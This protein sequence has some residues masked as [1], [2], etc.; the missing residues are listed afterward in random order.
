MPP[1][2]PSPATRLPPGPP[3]PATA[4]KCPPPGR[5]GPPPPLA[6]PPLSPP[7][8]PSQTARTAPAAH[9]RPGLA[10]V[11][12][13]HPPSCA[14]SGSQCTGPPACPAAAQSR[15]SPSDTSTKTSPPSTAPQPLHPPR[16]SRHRVPDSTH[17]THLAFLTHLTSPFSWSHSSPSTQTPSSCCI[18][19][20]KSPATRRS[21]AETCPPRQSA[22]S[23]V[24]PRSP[25]KTPASCRSPPPRAGSHTR[26]TLPIASSSRTASP[27][28]RSRGTSSRPET[29]TRRCAVSK[30]PASPPP[31]AAKPHTASPHPQ[32]HPA[33]RSRSPCRS[34]FDVRCSM[35]AVPASV[36]PRLHPDRAPCRRWHS[37]L[38]IRLAC[39]SSELEFGFPLAIYRSWNLGFPDIPVSRLLFPVFLFSY[40]C[41]F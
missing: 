19:R 29:Q 7:G 37:E 22:A 30:A 34:M 17:L 31:T 16:R 27:A 26:P 36:P 5:S 23:D 33:T 14:P 2:A 13:P 41:I 3:A 28:T 8:F 18:P 9:S 1:A 38:E 35:F 10:A 40:F 4:P 21:L 15:R 20:S 6:A 12:R 32:A 24:S 39:D 25:G 11:R